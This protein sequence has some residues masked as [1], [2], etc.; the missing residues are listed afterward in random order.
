MSTNASAG[1][2]FAKALEQLTFKKRN[3]RPKILPSDNV[4]ALIARRQ[5]PHLLRAIGR[6]WVWRRKLESGDT[7]TLADIAQAEGVAVSFVSRYLRLAY[8]SPDVLK[9]LVTERQTCAISIEALASTAV[10]PWAEQRRATFNT[11]TF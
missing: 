11:K 4:E 1:G 2:E 7:P 8:L 9:M 5:D 3:G 6:A 10:L